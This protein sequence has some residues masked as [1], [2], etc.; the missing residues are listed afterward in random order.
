MSSVKKLLKK[1]EHD[2]AQA[3][4]SAREAVEAAQESK[5]LTQGEMKSIDKISAALINSAHQQADQRTLKLQLA[6]A[7]AQHRKLER[8]RA[9]VLAEEYKKPA[10]SIATPHTAAQPAKIAKTDSWKKKAKE[11]VSEG[12]GAPAFLK[13]V[14]AALTGASVPTDATEQQLEQ[15]NILKSPFL[16]TFNK[17]IYQSTDV[18][19]FVTVSHLWHACPEARGGGD[20]VSRDR[21]P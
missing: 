19:E 13:Y 4:A 7:Q 14:V 20:L 16:V 5:K 17:E 6:A 21:E 8:E 3:A 2:I 18:S 11:V 1:P 15:A 12:G 9:H 10:R